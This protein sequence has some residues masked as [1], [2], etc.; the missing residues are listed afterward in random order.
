MLK[1]EN[2]ESERLKPNLTY[3][4]DATNHNGPFLEGQ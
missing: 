4:L 1:I 3:E 2:I